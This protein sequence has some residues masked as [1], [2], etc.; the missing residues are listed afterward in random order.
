MV[1]GNEND[2]MLYRICICV[3]IYII[4]VHIGAGGWSAGGCESAW[5]KAAS[6]KDGPFA[7]S[8]VP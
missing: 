8:K 3:C 7:N 5:G 6:G 2:A 1:D 4:Y